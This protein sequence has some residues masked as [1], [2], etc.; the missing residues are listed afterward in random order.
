L[1]MYVR[2]NN[3]ERTVVAKAKRF[4]GGVQAGHYVQAWGTFRSGVLWMRYG[5]NVSTRSEFGP[6]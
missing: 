5:H 2:T 6:I 4:R 3:G 1:T